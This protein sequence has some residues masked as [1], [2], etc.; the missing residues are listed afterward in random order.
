MIIC[1]NLAKLGKF[2][3]MANNVL[4]NLKVTMKIKQYL[5]LSV[6]SLLA[7]VA[8]AQTSPVCEALVITGHPAYP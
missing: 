7:T 1:V 4:L 3:I 2:V 6:L 5:M 8:F